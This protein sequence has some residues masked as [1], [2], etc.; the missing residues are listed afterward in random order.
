MESQ[1]FFFA[2]ENSYALK[3]EIRR[4]KESFAAKHGPENLQTLLGATQTVSSL[5]DAVAVMPFIAERRLVLCEG[6]PKIDKDGLSR[7]LEVL[8][9]QVIFVVYETKVDK[10]LG[11]VK[12]LFEKAQVKH[13]EPLPPAQLSAWVREYAA[14]RGAAMGADAVRSLLGV[15]GDD[16]WMLQGEIDKLSV[17]AGGEITVAHIE[18]LCVPSGS[19]VVWQLTD[20]IGGRKSVQALQFFH[21]RLERGEE[22]YGMWV[23]L[24]NMIKN[25]G[26]VRICLD[27]GVT[28][29]KSISKA[30]GVHFFG[31]RGLLPLA[32]SLDRKRAKALVDWA[33]ASDVALKTGE[34]KYTAE[35]PEELIALAERA[36][37]AC[38]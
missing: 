8:H 37:L 36:I 30:S 19:Q 26:A 32:R 12:D 34:L 6:V 15:A 10:R 17:Y 35:R 21:K 18:L 14:S 25:I 3:H 7:V 27:A 24:L 4:W 23:I 28:D 5:M 1:F 2:G 16:Q 22:P 29:E 38:A 31:V 11:I 20:L 33:A 9:P 13:F